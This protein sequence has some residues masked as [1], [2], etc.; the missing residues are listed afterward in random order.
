MARFLITLD[1][2]VHADESAAQSAITAAGASIIKTYAFALTFE[3]EATAEQISSITGLL[4]HIDAATTT[5]VSVQMANQDH[6]ITLAVGSSDEATSYNPQSTGAGS[7]IYLV[8]TGLY[9]EHEQFTGRNINYLYSNFDGDFTDE[10]GHG[11]AVAS[12]IVG[13]TQGVSKDATLHVIKLF[14]TGTGDIT[15]GE[16]LNA[17]D[18]VLTHHQ[19]NDPSKAKVVCLPW[20]TPQNNFID[21]KITELN[22]NNLVVVAAAGNDGQDVNNYSPA[23]VESVIT[24][25]SHNAQFE[26]SSFTNVPWTNPATPYYNNY[27]AALD[28]F[29]VGVDV[30]CAVIGD[31]DSYGLVS[32]TSVSSGIVAGVAAQWAAKYSTKTSSE[33]K[34][35]ILQ[36][37]HLPAVGKL[38]IDPS[39]PIATANLYRSIITVDLVGDASIGNLPSG[40]VMNVEL[41]QSLTKDLELNLSGGTEFSTLEFAPLPPWLTL[42]MSTGV[43]TAN[44]V[45][46]DASLAPGIYL[47]GIKATVNGKVQVEEYSVGLY[48][49]DPSELEQ[50]SQFY[51]DT[52]TANYDEV[53]SYQVAPNVSKF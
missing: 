44:T 20:V 12:V 30:S 39:L 18:A 32:G 53:I 2:G 4:D 5:S 6:L 7:H 19:A 35:I 38:N 13:N 45:G 52:E 28:I 10:S 21:S 8:D 37:G 40:R 16:I 23:G 34:D 14:D 26:V 17:L 41:G 25:G 42:D 47:F 49:N 24:V 1:S 15:I 27:G 48:A 11:T 46:L 36:E 29:A 9:A 31:V 22:T 33:L 50:A 3:V 51:Y 43:L